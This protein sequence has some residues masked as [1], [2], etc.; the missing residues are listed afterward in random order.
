M[1]PAMWT[2]VL[3]EQKASVNSGHWHRCTRHVCKPRLPDGSCDLCHSSP[4]LHTECVGFAW[5]HALNMIR[6]LEEMQF[7]T[8][9]NWDEKV[10]FWRSSPEVVNP[11]SLWFVWQIHLCIKTPLSFWEKTD[12]FS[13]IKKEMYAYDEKKNSSGARKHTVKRSA[14]PQAPSSP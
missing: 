4:K 2:F 1:V 7:P 5:V 13:L 11:G 8:I 3:V 6:E 14:F 12:L 9:L 10:L